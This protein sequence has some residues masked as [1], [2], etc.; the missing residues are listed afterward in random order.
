MGGRVR[1]CCEALVN[2]RARPHLLCIVVVLDPALL[3]VAFGVVL[4]VEDKSGLLHARLPHQ[5]RELRQ[6]VIW[7]ELLVL[8]LGVQLVELRKHS[9]PALGTLKLA[10]KD[11]HRAR[12]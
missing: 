11:E 5:L 12:N 6:R 8:V 10:L 2:S 1:S 9:V 3:Q 7:L 4:V